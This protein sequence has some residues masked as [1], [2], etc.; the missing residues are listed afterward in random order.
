MANTLDDIMPKILARGLL[1]LRQ[2]CYMPR[3]VNADFSNEAAQKGDTID[4]PVS[5]AVT[6]SNVT[7]ANTPPVPS[8]SA[9]TKVQV[10][11]DNW[12]HADFHLTDN[13]LAKINSNAHFMPLQMSEAIKALA[14]AVNQ[15]IWQEYL[16]VFGYVGTAGTTPFAS[17]DADAR[18][19]RKTLNLQLCPRASRVCVFNA[20]AE[21]NALGLAS[22]ANLEQTG[23]QDVKIEGEL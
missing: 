22:F 21:A 5:A 13:D 23:D 20:D 19:V 18:N 6:A 10:P 7:P 16:G 15:D 12:K 17:S 1:A 4:V 8:N 9:P 3:L 2:T 14:N 11:L